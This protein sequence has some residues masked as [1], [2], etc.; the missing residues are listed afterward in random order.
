ME[1]IS[2][3]DLIKCDKDIIKSVFSNNN[4]IQLKIESK[5][6]FD[7]LM[8]SDKADL[9]YANRERIV[10]LRGP[11]V[12]ALDSSIFEDTALIVSHLEDHLGVTLQYVTTLPSGDGKHITELGDFFQDTISIFASTVPFATDTQFRTP[13]GIVE[14]IKGIYCGGASYD[15]M[16]YMGMSY[17]VTE[18][19]HVWLG[20]EVC[21]SIMDMIDEIYICQPAGKTFSLPI[22]LWLAEMKAMGS[23]AYIT[24]DIT[25]MDINSG[26]T[27]ESLI[28]GV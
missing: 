22:L 1:V 11:I 5:S 27:V 13:Y 24:L 18:L 16:S 7:S 21:Y 10:S 23:N 17:N 25:N 8:K 6:E 3:I 28:Q 20:A 12:S 9:I 14:Y 26:L 2:S 19:N 4:R 15:K